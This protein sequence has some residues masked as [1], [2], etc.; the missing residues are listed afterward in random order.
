MAMRRT[1][2]FTSI[3][4]AGMLAGCGGGGGGS[5]TVLGAGQANTT[6]AFLS[7]SISVKTYD[8][9]SDDLLTAGL[10]A[11]GLASAT[12]P[13][14]SATPT[15]AELRRLAIHQNYRALVDTSANGGYGTLYGP[16][17]ANGGVTPSATGKIAGKEYIAYADDGS[18]AQNVVLMVQVPDT[19][20]P[21][22]PCIVT[23]TSS[24][25]RGIYGAIGTSG[26]WGLKR[27]CAVAYTDKGSGNG[28]HDLQ[29]N[30][31]TLI[32]GTTADASAAGKL[33]HFRANISEAARTAYNALFP[34]RVAYKHAHS[35]QN[36]EK[37]WG[38]DTLRAVE[39]AFYVLN[40]QYGST[41]ANSN[42][43]VRSLVPSN[44]TVIA[45]SVSNGGGAALAAAE[46]DNGGLIDAIVV[47]EPQAQPKATSGLTIR[48]GSNT[49][50]TIGKPLADYFTYANIYQPCAALAVP[51]SAFAASLPAANAEARCTALA[52]KNMVAG[53]TTAER[54]ADALAKLRAYGWEADTDILHATHYR[55]ATPSIAMTYTNTLGRF[56]VTDN[57]CGLSFANTDAAGNVAAQ[58]APQATLFGTGNGVPPTAGVNIVYNDSVGGA[59]LDRLAVSPSTNL[60]DFALD[61][62]LCQR[63]LVTGTDPV[64]G[65]ALTGDVL[66]ASRRVQQGIS[67]VQ[68]N[69]SVGSRPT[70]IV[71]GRSDTLI[72]VNHAA[73]A[74]FGK[75][76]VNNGG[77]NARY[78]EVT[79]ANHF[80]SFLTFPGYDTALIPLHYYFNQALDMMWAHLTAG[81]A[82]PGNQ[83]VRTTP[84][85]G[86]PGA[87]PA[88]T[89]ANV[90]DIAVTPA[91]ANA[92]TFANNTLTIA[93]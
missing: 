85:G 64:T 57:L 55:F 18:G 70:L 21:S 17:V 62:A 28:F 89:R 83:V 84:R 80:D 26:E 77:P 31:V 27:G 49:V 38:R 48:R 78:I 67:E 34:N 7:G 40:E 6:P 46:Q 79:N 75:L 82:L 1:F 88:I 86:S 76:Q 59:K 66:A 8:G 74:Y 33:A 5:S 69:G 53:A 61:A 92:I 15:A 68:L 9:N 2:G 47:S 50:T 16:T 54:A 3:I 35:Q 39:F 36:P 44:T 37:D 93:D 90:P 58:A 19:F 60:A 22:R 32:D 56:G 91:A 87:A 10:G 30:K 71:A 45:S 51:N 41:I 4:T 72:P 12:A 52:Q 24:G 65:A 23:A 20:S 11:A 42:V 25:S 73:R 29:S 14:V 43:K 81:A 63:A 13:A